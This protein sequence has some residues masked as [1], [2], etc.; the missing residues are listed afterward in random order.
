[1]SG[2]FDD[3]GAFGDADGQARD[4]HPDDAGD[5]A[6]DGRFLDGSEVPSAPVFDPVEVFRLYLEQRLALDQ[7]MAGA[8]SISGSSLA[9]ATLGA[10]DA[11]QLVR[12][13][14]LFLPRDPVFAHELTRVLVG[15]KIDEHL[16]AAVRGQATHEARRR[17]WASARSKVLP[18]LREIDSIDRRLHAMEEEKSEL[19]KQREMACEMARRGEEMLRV[20]VFLALLDRVSRVAAVVAKTGGFFGFVEVVG[21]HKNG[22]YISRKLNRL[23]HDRA[24]WDAVVE[25]ICD[26][27]KRSASSGTDAEGGFD[28]SH[29]GA[30]PVFDPDNP[31]SLFEALGLSFDDAAALASHASAGSNSAFAPDYQRMRAKMQRMRG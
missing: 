26:Y 8:A 13:A 9:S 6:H 2:G 29:D 17:T 18:E 12:L 3:P 14:E 1:M 19:L 10:R 25:F 22:D 30:G 16:F 31:A 5:G 20:K 21:A 28:E 24:F 15:G 11:E 23:C 7:G 4:Y 27:G